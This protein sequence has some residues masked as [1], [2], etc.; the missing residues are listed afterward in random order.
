MAKFNQI[1]VYQKIA[2]TG[3]VPVFYNADVEVAQSV[4]KACYDGGVRAFEFTNRGDFAHEV[5]AQVIKFVRSECPELALGVG[6]VIDAPTAVLYM[7]MGADFVVSPLLNPEVSRVCN[8]RCVPYVPGCGSVSEVSTAQEL[9]SYIV[10]CFPGN[11]VHGSDRPAGNRSNRQQRPGNRILHPDGQ[12][13][14]D[15]RY[16]PVHCICTGYD[17]RTQQHRTA[18]LHPD[19]G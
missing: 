9:G 5:F 12:Q 16:S 19:G 15:R 11:S 3:M 14:P 13:V 7:Q 18:V 8:R 10:K 17:Q 4:I 1:E 2:A 6:T